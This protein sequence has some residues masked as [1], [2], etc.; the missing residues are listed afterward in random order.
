MADETRTR[1]SPRLKDKVVHKLLGAACREKL[2]SR[3]G[4]SMVCKNEL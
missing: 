4:G 1:Q 2:Q 3:S